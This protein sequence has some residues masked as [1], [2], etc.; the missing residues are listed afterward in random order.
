MTVAWAQAWEETER[1]WGTRP[2]G[3][4]IHSTKEDVQ[5][6]INDYWNSMPDTIPD[7]YSRPVGLPVQSAIEPGHAERLANSK[8]GIRVYGWTPRYV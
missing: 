5:K 3:Y 8:N 1:G 4:S 7:E 6:F 2:D